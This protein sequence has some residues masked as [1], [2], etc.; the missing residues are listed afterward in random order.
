MKQYTIQTQIKDIKF[1]IFAHDT[2]KSVSNEFKLG[3]YE[4]HVQLLISHFAKDK[5]KILDIGANYGQHSI[6]MS[7]L[8]PNAHITAI[9]ASDSNIECIK[10]SLKFNLIYLIYDNNA[11]SLFPNFSKA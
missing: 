1:D 5:L 9:E 4:P 6:F 3:R 11:S 2:D 8:F 7:K 10:E